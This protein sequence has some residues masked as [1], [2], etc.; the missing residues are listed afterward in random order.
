VNKVGQRGSGGDVGGEL[1]LLATH[2]V[3]TP[4]RSSPASRG[5]GVLLISWAWGEGVEGEV[6][7]WRG[8]C[9]GAGFL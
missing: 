4:A 9:P 8:K 5:Q 6:V 1:H 2:T 3:T 7:V